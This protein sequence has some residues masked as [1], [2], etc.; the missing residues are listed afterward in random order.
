MKSGGQATLRIDEAKIAQ[1]SVLGRVLCVIA[2][3]CSVAVYLNTLRSDSE[4]VYDDDRQIVK[5]QFIRDSSKFGEALT[6]DVW[7]F[8]GHRKDVRVSNYWRPTFV[9][10]MMGNY[11][12]FGLTSAVGWHATNLVFHALVT[13]LAYL[14]MRRVGMAG[15]MAGGAALLFAV[16]PA[17][18]ESVAWISGSPDLI[19]SAA[20]LG[21]LVFV[22]R[23][24]ERRSAFDW[25]MAIGL[26]IIGQGAKEVAILFPLLAASVVWVKR[27]PGDDPDSRRTAWREVIVRAT[28]FAVLAIGYLIIRRVMLGA[29]PAG[30]PGFTPMQT[31]MNL[32]M[33]GAFYLKQVFWP[34]P[35]GPS[36]PL[37][38]ITDANA[39]NF[40]IPLVVCLAATGI[41]MWLAW[42]SRTALVG[43]ALFCLPLAPAANI[44]ELHPEQIVHDRYL[45]LP[46]LGAMILVME[47]VG[48]VA[49]L[50]MKNREAVAT[51]GRI[52]VAGA[53]S[54]PLAWV[55]WH[56]N[57]AWMT[58]LA[59]AEAS[60]KSDP[61][62]AFNHSELAVML[63]AKKEYEG[64]LC[65]ADEALRIHEFA[66][67][68]WVKAE[69][70]MAQGKTDE[71]LELLHKALTVLGKEPQ[72]FDVYQTY[73]RMIVCCVK[74]NRFNEAVTYAR[75]GQIRQP[76]LR[77]SYAHMMAVPL[78]YLKHD[79]EALR[80]LENV[81]DHI[82]EE[83]TPDS[84][85]VLHKLGL[86]Y[87]G[88]QRGAD[89]KAAFQEFLAITEGSQDPDTVIARKDAEQRLKLMGG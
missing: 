9:L 35:I 48:Q 19:L 40:V 8:K 25:V 41:A 52:G 74:A 88:Q 28:P 54:I 67:P 32:P 22:M 16:H 49:K 34:W 64:A 27:N 30:L 78:H 51:W 7:A 56:Y 63:N 13:L 15:A 62:S 80:E 45:Y 24:L 37:R 53:A 47:L 86:L 82:P 4:F 33:V 87:M 55:T 31:L 14:V 76:E 44:G 38:A 39:A 75:E 60:V 42:K 85:L 59:F 29:K 84:A 18:V 66:N 20:L 73:Q 68:Y 83:V 70:M 77:A 43:I 81:R 46:V 89:A 50:A 12:L 72:A 69:V 6:S 26:Y 71:A 10:W 79:D 2:V 36:Y 17:H 23:T 65:E 61:T 11:R 1:P 57:S 5:N 21:S 3:I 58:N